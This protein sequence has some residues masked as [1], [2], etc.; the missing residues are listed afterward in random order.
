[1]IGQ[2]TIFQSLLIILIIGFMG[3]DSGSKR[4]EKAQKPKKADISFVDAS[5]GL[6][7]SGQWRHALL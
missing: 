5:K 4:D 1:M 3:C 7:K 2:V 6:P